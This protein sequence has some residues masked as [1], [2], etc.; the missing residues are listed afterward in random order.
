MSKKNKKSNKIMMEVKE[1]TKEVE[2]IEQEV[3]QETE[4]QTTQVK[5]MIHICGPFY[6]EKKAKAE[7]EKESLLKKVGKP[8][9]LIATGAVAGFGICKAIAGI[10]DD[11]EEET[12]EE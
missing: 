11:G 3:N 8:I 7:E 9:G 6:R 12:T 2:A 5:E 1:M 4:E 10:E